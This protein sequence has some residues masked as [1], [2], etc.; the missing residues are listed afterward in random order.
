MVR[1][2]EHGQPQSS[3]TVGGDD[4]RSQKLEKVR[5]ICGGRKNGAVES[6]GPGDTSSGRCVGKT[7]IGESWNGPNENADDNDRGNATRWS[8]GACGALI[9]SLNET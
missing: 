3:F 5:T 4:R 1:E 7:N 8:E 2:V 9:G 6:V